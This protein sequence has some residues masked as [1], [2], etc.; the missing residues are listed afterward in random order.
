MRALIRGLGLGGYSISH[1]EETRARQEMIDG[2]LKAL[3]RM[4]ADSEESTEALDA[5]EAY[6]RR[7]LT[8]LDSD[9][10]V[11]TSAAKDEAEGLFRLGHKLRTWSG[12][13]RSGCATKT[14]STMKCCG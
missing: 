5:M 7:Q 13:S 1:E 4:R 10:S 11:S 12:P 2:A 8:L 14:R 6:Y 3:D 9:D